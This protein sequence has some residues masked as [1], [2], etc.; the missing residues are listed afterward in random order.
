MANSVQRMGWFPDKEAATPDR[1][2]GARDAFELWI[3]KKS[4][5]LPSLVHILRVLMAHA[6]Y[7]GKDYGHVA[8]DYCYEESLM[9]ATG[10]SKSTIERGLAYLEHYSKVFDNGMMAVGVSPL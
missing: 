10:Y 8:R 1:L 4:N 7:T 6:M 9:D 3:S 2:I 5:P